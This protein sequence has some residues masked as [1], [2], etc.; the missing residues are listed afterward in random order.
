[1]KIFTF[2]K[3]DI[4]NSLSVWNL[5]F[6]P[7]ITNVLFWFTTELVTVKYFVS[8]SLNKTLLA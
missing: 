4:V 6:E 3:P 7:S 2:A 1:L 8:I 5:F